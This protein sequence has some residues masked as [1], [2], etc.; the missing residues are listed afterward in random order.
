MHPHITAQANTGVL[1][2][3]FVVFGVS[4]LCVPNKEASMAAFDPLG[5]SNRCVFKIEASIAALVLFAG[6]SKRWPL[7]KDV[8]IVAPL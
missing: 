3:V 6:G 7:S 5:P 1:V 2:V 4:N 8:S